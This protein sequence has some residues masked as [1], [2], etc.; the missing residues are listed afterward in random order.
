MAKPKP[1]ILDLKGLA[2]A[3]LVAQLN[4][5]FGANTLIVA[6]KALGLTLKFHPTGPYAL[7]FACSG[8]IPENRIT[9]LRG[10]FSTLKTTVCLKAMAAFQQRYANG[11][12]FFQDGEK[13]F[14]PEYAR[15]LGVDLDRCLIVNA[16]SGEQA[17]DVLSDLLDIGCPA[18]VVIDSIATLVPSA[19]IESSMEQQFQ[20]L[21]PRLVN[22]MMRVLTGGLKR[23][24]YDA[25]AATVTVVATNQM[26]EKIG[27]IYG[28]P[29]TSPGG[30]G[31]EHAC[32]LMVKF[33]SSPSDRVM[34]K[35][36][37][38]GIEREIR[39]GQ[40]VRFT[41]TKNKVGGSQFE[42]GEFIFYTRTHGNN[43]IFT[44]DNVE[45]LFKFGRF[46][47]FIKEHAPSGNRKRTTY[48]YA[49]YIDEA[50]EDFFKRKLATNAKADKSLYEEILKA[51]RKEILAESPVGIAE[52]EEDAADAKLMRARAVEDE[53][54]DS[55][56]PVVL[57]KKKAAPGKLKIRMGKK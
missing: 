6:S 49:P 24:M 43:K 17:V 25:N 50:A 42:E 56:V 51:I 40:K 4:S 37:K 7:D 14:D 3:A 5:K 28:S 47:G 16:D 19:E 10:N 9:E 35:I 26:R 2:P 32:S 41:V 46:Y 8:G 23:V 45:V 15:I 39:V 29:E 20:G 18:F 52:A 12:A 13:S 30:K 48:S 55:V 57:V 36:T 11:I 1:Q 53:D 27:V 38:G 44:F 34:E 33:L 54:D 31:R 21:H 22:R